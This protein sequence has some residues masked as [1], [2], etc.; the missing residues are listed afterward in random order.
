MSLVSP[1]ALPFRRSNCYSGRRP[2]VPPC[3]I[4]G[5][6]SA[7]TPTTNRSL[8][9]LWSSP[10]ISPAKNTGEP[11]EFRPDRR[12]P[13]LRT[14]LQGLISF[15]DLLC[16]PWVFCDIQNLARDLLVRRFFNLRTVLTR[17]LKIHRKFRTMQN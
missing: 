7:P 14:Q 1:A 6:I 2:P 9:S 15:Q 8:S 12:R 3:T 17:A 5:A 11:L 4:A 10:A 16:E 13:W